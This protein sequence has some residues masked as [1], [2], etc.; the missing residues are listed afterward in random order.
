MAMTSLDVPADP[1]W[2][3][4]VRSVTATLAAIGADF[5]PET[6]D[7]VDAAVTEAAVE[8][9]STAGVERLDVAMTSEPWAL[10]LTGTGV[11]IDHGPSP[12]L[13][14]LVAVLAHVEVERSPD[15]FRI[16]LTPRRS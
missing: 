16:T 7:E 14:R 12:V 1:R 4:V 2:V 9:C 13:D 11:D 5:D 3:G 6:L 8:I 15:A 10:V